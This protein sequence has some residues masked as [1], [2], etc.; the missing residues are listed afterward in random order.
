VVRQRPVA[1][2]G[3]SAAGSRSRS[4]PWMK[5]ELP[6]SGVEAD[7]SRHR[8]SVGVAAIGAGSVDHDRLRRAPR[9][10]AARPP[11]Q[12]HSGRARSGAA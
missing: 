1:P 9:R 5:R 4:V 12:S 6:R 7:Q 11:G 10:R 2:A 3:R 8:G